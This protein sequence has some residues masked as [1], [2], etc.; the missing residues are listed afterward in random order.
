M[1]GD[2]RFDARWPDTSRSRPARPPRALRPLGERVRGARPR[3]RSAADERIDRDLV[4][5]ELAALPLL[6]DGAARGRLGPAGLGLPHRG[7][8]A[9]AD[10]RATS[11]RCA[12]RLDVVR[13]AA[14]GRAPGH[15]G[16]AGRLGSH[17][18][19]PGLAGCTR[20]SPGERIARGGGARAT[21]RSRWP[22][23]A[24][25]RPRRG[26]LLPRLRAAER[27]RQG[28]PRGDRRG[29]FAPEVAPQRER[30]PPSWAAT[31]FAAKLRYTLADP[32]VTPEA[33]LARA[34]REY[35][36]VRAEMVRI[37]REIWPQWCPATATCPP[38]RARWSAAVLD[39]IALE[40]PRGRRARGRLP[41][42]LVA[43]VEAFCR[44]HDVIGL[45]GRAP[46][47]RVD[48]RVHALVRR[49]R[50]STRPDPLDVGQ[51]SF[52]S[53]TPAAARVGPR[54]GRV[55]PARDEHAPAPAAH[56]PRGRARPLPPVRVREPS[57]ASLVRRVFRVRAVRRGLGRLRHAGHARPRV[58]AATT[59]RCGCRTGSSTCARSSTRSSTCGSTA[60]A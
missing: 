1:I 43:D 46:R 26:A 34:E 23:A 58:R 57:G 40:H 20:G 55:L 32:D 14:R 39:A 18:I 54:R 31:L 56:D 59:S 49:A 4:L 41:C 7:R 12:V 36:A 33:I 21:R 10:R 42:A 5:G 44:E 53:I 30:A 13:V 11:R 35:A 48:A 37:A 47:D 19:A 22:E 51:K 3:G 17:P 60:S 50:C 38:T 27:G 6:R 25:R 24:A 45:V 29:T 9:P 8:A 16:R 2:H 52:F 28:R 15:L